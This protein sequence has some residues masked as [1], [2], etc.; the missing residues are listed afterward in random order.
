MEYI[1]TLY[2]NTYIVLLLLKSHKISACNFDFYEKNK[3]IVDS[4][5]KYNTDLILKCYTTFIE[6]II[7]IINCIIL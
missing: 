4:M 3:N 1:N 6:L 5:S 2:L 7:I